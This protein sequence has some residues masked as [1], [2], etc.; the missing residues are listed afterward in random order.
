MVIERMKQCHFL[1]QKAPSLI[2]I[3]VEGIGAAHQKRIIQKRFN[4]ILCTKWQAL[5]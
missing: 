1:G 5:D 4:E 3:K 2:K